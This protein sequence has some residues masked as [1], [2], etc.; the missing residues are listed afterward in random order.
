ML[1]KTKLVRYLKL[2][3][4]FYYKTLVYIFIIYRMSIAQLQTTAY[5]LR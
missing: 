1:L 4:K 3:D 5:K 2:L